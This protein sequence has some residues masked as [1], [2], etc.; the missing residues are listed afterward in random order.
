MSHG[1]EVKNSNASQEK[2]SSGKHELHGVRKTV[3]KTKDC[4]ELEELAV[5][6]AQR[7]LSHG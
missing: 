3:E 5:Q 6:R 2:E 4:R 1:T 7:S